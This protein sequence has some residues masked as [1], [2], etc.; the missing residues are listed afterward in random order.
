MDFTLQVNESIRI[1]ITKNYK[2]DGSKYLFNGEIVELGIGDDNS[3]S[4][5]T[6]LPIENIEKLKQFLNSLTLKK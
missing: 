1:E 4:E 3:V 2:L 6:P 5:W